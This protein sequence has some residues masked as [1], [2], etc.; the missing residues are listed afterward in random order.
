MS[1]FLKGLKNNFHCLQTWRSGATTNVFVLFRYVLKAFTGKVG[2][3]YLVTYCIEQGK[4]R[5]E[6]AYSFKQLKKIYK[7]YQTVMFI[8]VLNY[9]THTN[10][11][12]GYYFLARL[13]Y[14]R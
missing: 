6:V 9:R 12:P 10:S 7:W 4:Q 1:E 13:L 14:Y 2:I 11:A 3:L 5:W 8:M